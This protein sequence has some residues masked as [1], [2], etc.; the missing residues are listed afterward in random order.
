MARVLAKA[1]KVRGS[2]M[3][4]KPRATAEQKDARDWETVELEVRKPQK[5]FFGVTPGI[6]PFMKE[7]KME[8]HVLPRRGQP[9]PG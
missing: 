6:G 4:T 3:V 8:D 5:S 7:D 9:A 2:L 1:R